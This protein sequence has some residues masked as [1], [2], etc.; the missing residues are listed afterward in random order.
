MY[1][2]ELKD[3]DKMI[4]VF[5]KTLQRWSKED[6]LK[7]YRNSKIRKYKKSI[8]EGKDVNQL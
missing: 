6:T 8:S 4:N 1:M 5:F 2:Y 3:F 7:A